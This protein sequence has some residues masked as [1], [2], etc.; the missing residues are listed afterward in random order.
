MQTLKVVRTGKVC[1]TAPVYTSPEQVYQS[2][3]KPMSRLDRE[4]F[5]VLH[6]DGRHRLIAKET[7]SIGSLNQSI[8]HPREVFKAAV[9]N[10]SAAVIFVHNHPS[11]DPAPSREDTAI[12]GRLKDAAG[13]LGIKVLD[14]I[15]FGQ[16]RYYSMLE[17]GEL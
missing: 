10:N 11:G 16:N 7:V 15:I 8:V 12:T 3:T 13:I 14:H 5:V 9:L 17:G 2:L 1:E 6:L 4:H